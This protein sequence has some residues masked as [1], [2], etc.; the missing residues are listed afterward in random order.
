MFI[1]YLTIL[2]FNHTT[3]ILSTILSNRKG[4]PRLN[5]KKDS[6]DYTFDVISV[7]QRILFIKHAVCSC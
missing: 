4:S 5:G 7:N 2:N 1:N 3:S 6:F